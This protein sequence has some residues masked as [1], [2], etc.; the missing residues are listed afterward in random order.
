MRPVISLSIPRLV[1]ALVFAAAAAGVAANENAWTARGPEIT[2]VTDAVIADGK[3][4]AATLNGVFRSVDQGATWQ[5]IGLSGRFIDQVA[6]SGGTVFARTG[7]E[8]HVSRDEGTTWTVPVDGVN[9]FALDPVNPSI[10]F[11]A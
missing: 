10:V 1:P 8:L 7:G 3:A 4:Y 6:A 2:W 5:S 11:A 9:T